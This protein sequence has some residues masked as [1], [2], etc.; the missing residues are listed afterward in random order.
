M[1]LFQSFAPIFM[2]SVIMAA[3]INIRVGYSLSM[4]KVDDILEWMRS[5]TMECLLDDV[6]FK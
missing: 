5:I 3:T 4:L 1:G 2:E 6:K